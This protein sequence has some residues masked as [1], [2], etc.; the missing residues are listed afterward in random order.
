MGIIFLLIKK[1]DDLMSVRNFFGMNFG[2]LE[3]FLE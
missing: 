3:T 1:K 2:F